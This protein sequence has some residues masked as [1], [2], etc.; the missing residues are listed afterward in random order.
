MKMRTRRA[1]GRTYGMAVRRFR[2]RPIAFSPPLPCVRVTEKAVPPITA[3]RR[4][5]ERGERA[6]IPGLA[7]HP[8]RA[9]DG[10]DPAQPPLHVFLHA[11]GDFL[12][13]FYDLR[14]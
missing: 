5:A 1:P 4:T 6:R 9:P 10:H 12:H 2:L 13:L 14:R 7:P 3:E 11:L 8:T